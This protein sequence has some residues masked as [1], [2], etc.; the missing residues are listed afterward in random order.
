MSPA[1]SST[2]Q[3]AG[4]ALLLLLLLLL[5][6]L[7]GKSRLPPR[8][9]IYSSL[10]WGAGAFPYMHDEIFEEEGDID[11]AFMGSS[12][13]WWGIDTPEVQAQLSEK[14]GRKAVVRSLCWNSPGF[15]AFYFILEDL[16]RHRNV[17]VVVFCDLSDGAA[18][19]AHVR[20]PG[21][22]RMGD[23]A[24]GIAGLPWMSKPSFYGSA[25]LGMPRNL[26][27]LARP[28]LPAIPSE[29]ISW[30]AFAHIQNPSL[31]LG[32]LVMSQTPG[33][34]F[35]RYA[36]QDA[37]RPEDVCVYSE[38]AKE[39]FH[40]SGTAIPPM[41]AAFARKIAALARERHV[42]LV[43]LHVPQSTEIQAAGIEEPVFWPDFFQ[44]DVTMAG[45]EPRKLYRGMSG[46]DISKLFWNFEHFNQNGEEYFT[47]IISPTLARIY[48]E[49]TKP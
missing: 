48:E 24:E 13:L 2:R 46:E 11:I 17:R 28:N 49:Q 18:N 39:N 6:A 25:I 41:Q 40:F 30:G 20:A 26:L 35:V 23:N 34:T 21:W 4:F 33:Q 45:I 8:E 14:L 15:D 1:F 31:R 27:E 29:E 22:F 19:T 32:S 12:R 37:A 16:L 42:K 3:A 38:A 43:Y 9:E 10:P 7:V 44:G 5:P 47:R 36:P